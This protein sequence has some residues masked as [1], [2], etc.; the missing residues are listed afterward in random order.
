VSARA[1]RRRALV[2]LSL[3]LTCG[4]LAASEVRSRV[5]AVERRAGPLTPVLVAARDIPAGRRLAAPDLA[6]RRVPGRYLPRDALAGARDVLG[7]RTAVRMP[8]GAYLSASALGG[9]GA[10]RGSGALRAGE[11][12]VEVAVAGGD[13][14]AQTA[15]PGSRVDV[16]VSSE[17]RGG[18]GRTEL[19][20]EDAELLALRPGAPGGSAGGEGDAGTRATAI[21]TLRVTLRQAIFLTQA[22]N[23]AREVRLLARPA[24]ER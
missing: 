23:F 1:R 7:A 2:L 4:G 13:A 15:A 11:R 21:A 18:D 24:R 10:R 5:A 12:A 16:L 20:L 8:A 9:E 14:L 3:A 6:T 17:P 19:A 22:E